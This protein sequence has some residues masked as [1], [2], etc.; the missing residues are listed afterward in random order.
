[1]THCYQI[2]FSLDYE[3]FAKNPELSM[4]PKAKHS[5][6]IMRLKSNNKAKISK[7]QLGAKRPSLLDELSSSLQTPMPRQISE[8]S[9]A[10]FPDFIKLNLKSL[11]SSSL[12]KEERMRI[13]YSPF[14]S[15]HT[16]LD[17]KKRTSHKTEE[18]ITRE[19]SLNTTELAV[20]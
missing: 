6:F 7:Y 10:H 2:K 3:A 19:E 13:H 9:K 4:P 1:M 18:R 12:K 11:V 5:S 14:K 16:G 17:W 15:S 8:V 20:V